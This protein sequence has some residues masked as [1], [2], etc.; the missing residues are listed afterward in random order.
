MLLRPVAFIWVLFF[1]FLSVHAQVTIPTIR[2]SITGSSDTTNDTS[3]DDLVLRNPGSPLETVSQSAFTVEG[4][5]G[6]SP[7][8][9]QSWDAD[10]NAFGIIIGNYTTAEFLAQQVRVFNKLWKGDIW[11]YKV[12]EGGNVYYRLTLGTYSKRGKAKIYA[13]VIHDYEKIDVEVVD[14]KKL[15]E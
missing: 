13:D 8:K 9:I 2:D 11:A 6:Y 14:L 1:T 12:D 7:A 10:S 4:L 5:E 3:L 15:V